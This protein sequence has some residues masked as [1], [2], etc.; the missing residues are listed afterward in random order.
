MDTQAFCHFLKG[1]TELTVKQRQRLLKVIA[2]ASPAK[3]EA[4]KDIP[5]FP[6]LRDC[7]HCHAK[8]DCLRPWGF[9]RG[10]QRYRCLYCHRTCTALTGSP[11]A[12][13]HHPECWATY[14]QALI[15]GC[16]V[17]VAAKQC[18]ISKNTAF[19]WRHR[20]LAEIAARRDEHES[21]IVEADE[22]FFLESFKGQRK[23]PRLARRRGGVGKTRGTGAE[24]IP[25]LVGRDRAGHTAE[26]KL[27]K[28]DSPHVATHLRPL[29]DPDAVLCT[30]GAAVY[31]NFA[32]E[33]RITHVVVQA[34]PGL[35]VKG[36]AY[37]I[38]NVNAYHSRLKNWMTRFHGVATRYLE[39]Y[40]GWRR[41]LERYGNTINP[42]KCIN[43]A[44]GKNMQH[45][46]GT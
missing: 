20:F 38:Q 36:G 28:L 32:R 12:R 22:T 11:L 15:N 37:H 26:I 6:D 19:H 21:G 45:N 24:Q 14:A 1:L 7:P 33:S 18:G 25:V 40:L 42:H 41:L 16:T 46:F 2:E 27:S 39:N 17:R 34:K 5:D 10:I 30:D 43:E 44:I 23:L 3:D 9:T 4:R 35:R 29:I 13:L 31:A 8:S